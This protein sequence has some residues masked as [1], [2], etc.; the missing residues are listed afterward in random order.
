[1]ARRRSANSRL[2]DSSVRDPPSGGQ[3]FL[4]RCGYIRLREPCR[5]DHRSRC[6]RSGCRIRR[7][8]APRV[9][10]RRTSLADGRFGQSEHQRNFIG[11]CDRSSVDRIACLGPGERP[12][13]H[14]SGWVQVHRYRRM[15]ERLPGSI[16]RTRGRAARGRGGLRPVRARLGLSRRPIARHH[17]PRTAPPT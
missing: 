7:P 1:M 13:A 16:R 14:L 12:L 5:Q 6:C 3:T 4:A 8:H 2:V 10:F 11:H 15:P 17:T 9:Y